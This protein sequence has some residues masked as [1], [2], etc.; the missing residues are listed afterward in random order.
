[1]ALTTEKF[2][3]SHLITTI[4]AFVILST[5]VFAFTYRYAVN[6]VFWDE[7]DYFTPLWT[8]GSLKD[9][10]FWQHGPHRMGVG[11]WI[12]AAIAKLTAWNSVAQA[13]GSAVFLV[14]TAVIYYILKLKLTGRTHFLDLIFPILGLSLVHYEVLIAGNIALNAFPLFGVSVFAL[15]YASALRSWVKQALLILIT[16][17]VTFS[18][19]GVFWC[20]V[21]IGLILYEEIK[22]RKIRA[23]KICSVLFLCLLLYLMFGPGYRH[24]SG[25]SC[26]TCPSPKFYQYIIFMLSG[27]AKLFA[28]YQGVPL[29][30]QVLVAFAF[31]IFSIR[32]FYRRGVKKLR[33]SI[34]PVLPALIAFSVIFIAAAALGRAGLSSTGGRESRYMCYLLPAVFACYIWI[35]QQPAMDTAVGWYKKSGIWFAVLLFSTYPYHAAFNYDHYHGFYFSIKE[36]WLKS[37]RANQNLEQADREAGG[38]IFPDYNNPA[39]QRGMKYLKENRFNLFRD[40]SGSK[41]QF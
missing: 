32:F 7:W 31:L 14:A 10:F 13:F 30:V 3:H 35:A 41:V 39:F 12:I 25:A 37:F 11:Y 6:L 34:S 33:D 36:K 40:S 19:F 24:D 23:S 16:A 2:Q 29:A 18:G 21:H 15:V 38:K 8:N 27:F 9:L 28:F 4:T 20:L 1:M 17:A 26:P 5:V 22:I